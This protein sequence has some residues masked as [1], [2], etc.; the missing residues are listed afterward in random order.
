[1][2]AITRR[3]FLTGVAGAAAI[4]IAGC[5]VEYSG[6]GVVGSGSVPDG[7]APTLQ[8]ITEA[9]ADVTVTSADEL[10][11]LARSGG[12][13][14]IWI[15]SKTKID[16]TGRNL[17]IDN[18]TIAS[19]R[20]REQSGAVL[21]TSDE[22][23]NSPAWSGGSGSYGLI[24]MRNNARLTGVVVQ[25]PHTDIQDHPAMPGYFPFAPGGSSARREWRRERFARGITVQ[26]D[27]VRIDNNEIWGWGVQGVAV[28]PEGF[29]AN[30]EVAYC[31]IHNCMMTSYGYCVDVRHGDCTV[32]RS[33]L[34]AARHAM[35]GS[36]MGDSNY[37]VVESTI[38][39]WTSSHPL[40]QHR[41][42]ENVSGSS[43]PDAVD[44]R[45]RAGG[46]VLVRGC[47]IMPT[48]VPDLPFIN[49][50]RGGTAPHVRIRGVPGDAVYFEDN[51]CGHDSLGDAVKQ[52][53]DGIPGR[54]SPDENGY[55]RINASGN[56]F[57]RTFEPFQSVP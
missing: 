34:D 28:G 1:M 41:V 25:G 21:T 54:Y 4:G 23:F 8:E 10:I 49:H 15:P 3:R 5:T 52:S 27:N 29:V 37:Y 46:T 45:Y 38:G 31:H 55:V 14:V 9:D 57:G 35:C 36:G 16:L 20:N 7:G 42:G 40:D 19:G 53:G 33:Y 22:G 24:T 51:V 13:L 18:T 30:C 48:R 6:G 11:E 32:Y 17:I 12:G 26:G 47:H 50:N 56:E 44:Y 2:S 43:D 39:P